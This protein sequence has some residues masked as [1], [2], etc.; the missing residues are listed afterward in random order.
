M[1]TTIIGIITGCL[2]LIFAVILFFSD[3]F[4]WKLAFCIG[5]GIILAALGTSATVQHKGLTITGGGAVAVILYFL[6]YYIGSKP[7]T[8]GI[9]EG[10]FNSK[11]N[12]IMY[13]DGYILGALRKINDTN[14]LYKFVLEGEGI[15]GSCLKLFIDENPPC[16]I[17]KKFIDPYLNKERTIEWTYNDKTK[18]ITDKQT[19]EKIWSPEIENVNTNNSNKFIFSIKPNFCYAQPPQDDI[20]QAIL[21]IQSDNLIIKNEG[22]NKLIDKKSDAIKPLISKL[23]AS[24]QDEKIKLNIL[25]V[26]SKITKQH[27]EST[28][29]IKKVLSEDDLRLLSTMSKDE[30]Q[31]IRKYSTE[32]LFKLSDPRLLKFNIDT[33]NKSTNQK[34]L[35]SPIL[36]IKSYYDILPE[37]DKTTIKK[38]IDPKYDNL[39]LKTKNLTDSY[40]KQ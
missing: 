16:E 17:E 7:I 23:S 15:K 12:I 8:Y 11:T 31:L 4:I 2:M 29:N 1:K 13:D 10:G 5:F 25:Y 22:Y 14:M 21:D 33:I 36:M 20:S 40:I 38:T 24:Q 9:I 34:D 26:L 35:Y 6:I 18:C 37:S 32:F 3:I 39:E 27:P 19:K 30:N 28:T